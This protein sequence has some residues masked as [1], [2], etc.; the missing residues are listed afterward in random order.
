MY[1]GETFAKV[2]YPKTWR[3]R[4]GLQ[5]G[6][7]GH[8]KCAI[9]KQRPPQPRPKSTANQPPS[10]HAHPKIWLPQNVAQALLAGW[11]DVLVGLSPSAT[12]PATS[13]AAPAPDSARNASDG[14]P[15]PPHPSE[16]HPVAHPHPSQSKF[17]VNPRSSAVKL[18]P[19]FSGPLNAGHRSRKYISP[20]KIN[21]MQPPA[22][23]Q[24]P[25]M[26]GPPG[27]SVVRRPSS[28]EGG[29]AGPVHGV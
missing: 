3:K 12:T 26:L 7:P 16:V 22:S 20:N 18:L 15:N 27:Y 5:R 1:F 13:A 14:P 21:N 4:P 10:G 28:R 24:R 19:P 17:R 8:R 11:A 9:G 6:P 25:E 23:I 2:P 29:V